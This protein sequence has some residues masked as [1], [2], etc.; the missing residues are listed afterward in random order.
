MYETIS[1]VNYIHQKNIVHRDLKPENTLYSFNTVKICDFGC[2]IHPE[3]IQEI[4][5]NK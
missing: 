1:A 2:S 3:N 5:R 4:Q